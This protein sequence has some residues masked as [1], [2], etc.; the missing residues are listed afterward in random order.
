MHKG[1]ES[2]ESMSWFACKPRMVV[3][4]SRKYFSRNFGSGLRD[5]HALAHVDVHAFLDGLPQTRAGWI[6]CVVEVEENGGK[7][8]WVII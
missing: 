5:A 2:C 4:Y 8:H 1:E 7:S 3:P 6:E